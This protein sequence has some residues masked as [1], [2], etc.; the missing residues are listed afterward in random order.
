MGF[1]VSHQYGI[2]GLGR[3]EK[4]LYFHAI[5]YEGGTGFGEAG[6]GKLE[7]GSGKQQKR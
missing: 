3:K 7:V 6:W 2:F 5:A 1:I 4:G